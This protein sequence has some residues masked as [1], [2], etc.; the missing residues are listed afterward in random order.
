MLPWTTKATAAVAGAFLRLAANVLET[1]YYAGVTAL[2]LR[3]H[4][5]DGL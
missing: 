4:P 2:P 1:R 3:P 5:P